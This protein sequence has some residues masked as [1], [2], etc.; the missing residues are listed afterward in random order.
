[1]KTLTLVIKKIFKGKLNLHISYD[2]QI[3]KIQVKLK[4]IHVFFSYSL[5]LFC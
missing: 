3:F 5:Q 2:S 4:Y 1:M